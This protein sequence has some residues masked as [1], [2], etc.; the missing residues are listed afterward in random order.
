MEFG[1]RR[2][3]RSRRLEVETSYPCSLQFYSNP[4]S[5]NISL[6]EFDEMAVERLK[7]L[8]TVERLNLSG[9]VK[10]SD[11]W[12]NKL[13]DD[14]AKHKYFILNAEKSL[15]KKR[16]DVE[17]ARRRDHISHF[18]LR[19]AYCRTE[20]LRRWFIAH[21]SDLFRARFIHCSRNGSDIKNF[22]L[23]NNLHFT[24]ISPEEMQSERENLMNGTYNISGVDQMEGRTFFKVPFTEALELV[25]SR[26]VFLKGGFA[27]VPDTDLVTLVTT[28][29]RA[30]LSQALAM[31]NRA[32]PELED[33]ERLMR[34]LQDFDKR[35]TG[36][37]YSQK[38]GGEKHRITPDM[39]D[40]LAATSFPLC[41]RQLN[42]TLRT[43]HHLRHGGRVTYGLFLKAA[44]LSLEDALYFWRSH[45]TKNMDVDKFDKQY[46]YNI[47]FNYGKEGKRTDYTPY[48]CMKIIMTSIGPGDAHGCP[49]K[50]T[51]AQMLRQRLSNFKVSQQAIN[52]I[53]DLVSKCHY[54]IACQRYWEVTHNASLETGINHPNQYFEESQ[55]VIHGAAPQSQGKKVSQV[56]TNRSI[57]YSSQSLQST[58]A[59]VEATQIS[60][61]STQNTSTTDMDSM[62][63]DDEMDSVLE[64]YMDTTQA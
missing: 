62:L 22:M 43:T 56:K 28:C 7:I 52:E 45:F 24:P 18:I 12:M 32:L 41:M 29:F 33:D 9:Q 61:Q 42:D 19:L 3:K 36:S 13:Y 47:R 31:T 51:D 64:Q 53:M 48:S 63:F 37:D 30:N 40:Q 34:L 20:E 23:S 1:E 35:Y 39:I 4:P 26:K 11:E 60:T 8:R 17:A 50:H 10:S 25:R 59:S 44:G 57:M 27:Y 54:Q 55:K 2:V 16:A 58:Q 6:M 15:E 5:G 21:E 38:K 49:F 14:F 46:A